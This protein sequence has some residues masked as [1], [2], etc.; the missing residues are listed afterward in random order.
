MRLLLLLLLAL[1]QRLLLLLAVSNRVPDCSCM[2]SLVTK[3]LNMPLTASAAAP[4]APAA[5]AAATA[6]LLSLLAVSNTLT[7]AARCPR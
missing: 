2:L 4:V 1:L 6:V 7:A 3:S 5:P